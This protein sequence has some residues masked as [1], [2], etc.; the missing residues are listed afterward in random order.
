M[1]R[2]QMADRV[3]DAATGLAVGGTVGA[4]VAVNITVINQWLQAGAFTVAIISGL[5]AAW[6]YLSN[7]KR[8]NED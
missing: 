2:E 4:T 8:S 1:I 5:C 6:Y 7:R 3:A